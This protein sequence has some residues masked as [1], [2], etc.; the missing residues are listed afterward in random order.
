MTGTAPCDIDG[1]HKKASESAMCRVTTNLWFC[2]S[3][4][5][6]SLSE[7]MISCRKQRSLLVLDCYPGYHELN[8]SGIILDMMELYLY[9]T[10]HPKISKITYAKRTFPNSSPCDNKVTQ[11]IP[12]M[13]EPARNMS[14]TCTKRRMDE[15]IST[16][17]SQ[18][19]GKAWLRSSMNFHIFRVP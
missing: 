10:N 14:A 11:R 2:V 7:T 8:F 1:G 3:S 5:I 18:C 9:E 15:A 13:P 17:F 6:T 4:L 16:V 12:V 19:S